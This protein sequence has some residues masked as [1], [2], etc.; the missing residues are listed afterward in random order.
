VAT[1]TDVSEL[2]A[3]QQQLELVNAELALQA[4]KLERRNRNL[5]LLNRL[6]QELGA[7]LE[8]NELLERISR[9]ARDVF[10]ADGTIIWLRDPAQKQDLVCGA[11]SY[12]GMEQG[13]PETRAHSGE[14]LIGWVGQQRQSVLVN[15]TREDARFRAD[16]DVPG[17]FSAGAVLAAPMTAHE[18][19]LGVLAVV[20]REEG[21][22]DAESLILVETLAAAAAI[23]LENIHLHQQAREAAVLGERSRLARELHD[24]VSQTLFSASVIAESL[25]RLW[26]HKPERVRQGLEQLQQLTRG[27]L[28]EMRAL[29]LEL[30]PTALAEG[31]M[32]DLLQQL[33]DAFTSRSR[34]SVALTVDSPHPYPPNVQIALY[35][36]AQEALNNVSKH[37]RATQVEV[38]L[39][40]LGP[41][42]ELHIRDNGRGFALEH[43]PPD[44]LGLGILRERAEAI[45]A[46]VEISS[47]EGV[48]TEVSVTWTANPEGGG[49]VRV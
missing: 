18:Q 20:R 17:A 23:A 13:S 25:P 43:V 31:K 14:G 41:R 33:V 29:L 37:A 11:V 32:P 45:G 40:D 35:R 19:L 8:I 38:S 44:R 34:V 24:A 4:E 2:R 10:P 5:R 47:Q 16:V 42:V 30:R 3:I 15:C 6:S 48:G 22:F 26:E 49:D 28:S 1:F 27:A 46:A 12:P 39:R 21:E 9:A 7:A 36:I